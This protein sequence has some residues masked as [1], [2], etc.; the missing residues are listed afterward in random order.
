MPKQRDLEFN[1]SPN[2]TQI[3][4]TKGLK[5]PSFNGVK[6]N[7]NES[8]EEHLNN[9]DQLRKIDEEGKQTYE[10]EEYDS[11]M[12]LKQ[13]KKIR[14]FPTTGNSVSPNRILL[15]EKQTKIG[16]KDYLVEISRDKLHMY[17]IAFLIEKAK[18]Y[19]MQIP[20]KQAFKL[21]FELDNSFDTMVDLLYFSYNTLL[22]PDFLRTKFSPRQ[23]NNF[24]ISNIATNKEFQTYNED[25]VKSR[26]NKGTRIISI[27]RCRGDSAK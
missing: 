2:T 9:N 14:P 11:D 10:R 27:F 8:G 7:E 21:L 18:Y 17:I 6:G 24:S 15:F 25:D 22:L 19:T 20:I 3:N 16:Q 4:F 13:I 1:Q 26:D 23:V 5:F 12:R